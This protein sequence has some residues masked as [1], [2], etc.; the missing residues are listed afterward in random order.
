MN[1]GPFSLSDDDAYRRWRDAKLAAVPL[2][3][4]ELVVELRDPATPTAAERDALLERCRRANMAVYAGPADIGDAKVTLRRLAAAFGLRRL[5]AN[6]LAD[7]DGITPLAVAPEG[8]RTRYIPYTDRPISWHTDGYYNRLD[9]QVRGLVLHCAQPA[10]E[11]G[12]NALMD[13]EIAYI[14]LRERD[15]AL[16]AALMQP[17]AMTIPGNRDG[18]IVRPDRAGPV[19]MVHPVD[20]ALHMRYTARARNVVW[21]DDPTA[22]AA[23]QAL[24]EILAGGDYVIRHR[25]LPGQGLLCNN[26]LHNRGRFRDGPARG[27]RLLYRARFHDRIAGTAAPAPA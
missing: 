9:E 25:L 4:E 3:A 21:K 16:I 10:A 6:T 19:F 23:V 14:L 13:P 27:G 7:D 5:D 12:E 17:D 1:H 8:Q 18:A 24:E 20:G 2:R 11:G 22:R 26:V 15:P